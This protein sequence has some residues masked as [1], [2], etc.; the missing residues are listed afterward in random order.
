M[1]PFGF[2]LVADS[3]QPHITKILRIKVTILKEIAEILN[4]SPHYL[5]L[6]TDNPTVQTSKT[7]AKQLKNYTFDTIEGAKQACAWL[8]EQRLSFIER[9][10]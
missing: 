9:L 7:S 10:L 6:R 2:T 3:S 8:D 4:V 1:F 5:M